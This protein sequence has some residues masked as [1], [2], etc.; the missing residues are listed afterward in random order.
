MRF[1]I[2]SFATVLA[3]FAS[4][5]RA[6]TYYVAPGGSDMA[7]GSESMPF[8]SWVKAQDV[9]AP[10]DTVYFRGGRYTFTD[11]LSECG[12]TSATVNAIALNKSGLADKPI[13]YFAY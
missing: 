10:G 2:L 7:D 12:S 1:I 3:A 11:A 4:P 13:E 5:V 9:A 6:A 8:A